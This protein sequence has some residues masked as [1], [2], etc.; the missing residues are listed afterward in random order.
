MPLFLHPMLQVPT[1]VEFVDIAGLVRGASKG[2][3]LGNKFLANIRET[4]AIC[5]VRGASLLQIQM[6]KL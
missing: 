2:E 6:C 4:D 5:Q 1:T 3:G